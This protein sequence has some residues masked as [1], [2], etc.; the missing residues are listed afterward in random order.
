MC[1][2]LVE[3]IDGNLIPVDVGERTD[4]LFKVTILGVIRLIV[5]GPISKIISSDEISLNSLI[6][7]SPFKFF[8]TTMS[9]GYIILQ[10]CVS[11]SE[12]I[13]FIIGSEFSSCNDFPI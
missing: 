3:W 8:A 1:V 9:S 12:K 4:R 2:L 13:S 7:G 6:C 5:F 11:E 10:F